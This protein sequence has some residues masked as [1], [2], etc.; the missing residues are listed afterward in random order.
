MMKRSKPYL[1]RGDRYSHTA[2][3][4]V[5]GILGLLQ[6]DP[7]LFSAFELWDKEARLYVRGCQAVAIQGTKLCVRVPSAAHRQELL[8]YKDRVLKKINQALGRRKITDVQ[9]EFDP[10]SK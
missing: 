1:K 4:A 9:F 7:E 6:F 5:D 3:S 2:K 8:S 10:F